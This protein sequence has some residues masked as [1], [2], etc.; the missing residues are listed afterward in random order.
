MAERK[1]TDPRLGRLDDLGETTGSDSLA[2]LLRQRS[3]APPTSDS[4]VLAEASE[5]VA[6]SSSAPR[7]LFAEESS[8]VLQRQ[9]PSDTSRLPG[10]VGPDI[11]RAREAQGM[12]LASLAYR[13]RLSA[14]TI[15]ALEQNR[16]QHLPPAYIRGYLR[17]IARELDVDPGPWIRS[18]E[19]SGVSEPVLKATVQRNL[20]APIVGGH[21]RTRIVIAGVLAFVA[22]VG[23]GAYLW[24]I[25]RESL[26]SRETRWWVGLIEFGQRDAPSVEDESADDRLDSESTRVMPDQVAVQRVDPQRVE[27]QGTEAQRAEPQRAEPQ[28]T[29]Q[30]DIPA[31]ERDEVPLSDVALDAVPTVA[32][33]PGFDPPRGAQPNPMDLG[34]LSAVSEPSVSL[35]ADSSRVVDS[36]PLAPGETL[37]RLDFVDTSWVEVR[38]ASNRVEMVGIFHNGDSQTLRMELPG[39]VVLGNAN[40]VRLYRDGRELDLQPFVRSDR[41]ARF[42][43]EKP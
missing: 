37:V 9:E 33:A 4:G 27:P 28:R 17:A 41:T 34:A 20:G 1:D 39:R 38:S 18:Y 21:L 3:P 8:P 13:T 10:G 6:G 24:T 31:S 19:A 5:P 2:G 7:P 42:N 32:E 11:R 23:V 36:A 14:A 16:F 22:F 12:D 29:E 26:E 25:D 15:E 40:G 30:Q 35:A 43:L